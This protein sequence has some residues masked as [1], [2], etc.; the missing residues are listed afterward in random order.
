[1][2]DV[3]ISALPAA[4]TLTG[5]EQI[6]VVQGGT[7]KRT[8][9]S[10]FATG[11]VTEAPAASTDNVIQPTAD[12]VPF[13]IRAFTTQ[14]TSL[15]EWLASNGSTVLAYVNGAGQIGASFFVDLTGVGP[16]LQTT[17]A[18]FVI[19]NRTTITNIP[20]IVKGMA[21]QSGHL[22]QWQDS[23]AAV[24]ASITSAGHVT[25]N[26]GAGFVGPSLQYETFTGPWLFL[27]TL[28]VTVQNRTTVGNIPFVVK[29]MASQSGDLQQW[30]DDSGTSLSYVKSD[31]R[32]SIDF[33]GPFHA[34]VDAG[35]YVRPRALNAASIPIAVR[36]AAAQTADLQQWQNSGGSVLAFV[37]ASGG[38]FASG[39][40]YTGS[41][42]HTSFTGPSIF[43]S[44]AA[45]SVVNA[46]SIANV[47]L[48]VKGM[49]GQS[50][51]LQQWQ[52]TGGSILA[53]INA[54]GY[55]STLLGIV[56][57]S[58]QDLSATGPSISLGVNSTFILNRTAVGNIPLI[59][60]GMAGQTGDLQQWK[61]NAGSPV[62]KI[63]N[64]GYGTFAGVVVDYIFDK[65]TLN[66]P[67]ITMAAASVIVTNPSAIGNIPFV[68]RGV[69]G[70]TGSLQQWQ[71]S[72]ANILTLIDPAGKI[73]TGPDIEILTVGQGL[74]FKSPDGTRYRLTVANGGALSAVAA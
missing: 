20:L 47:P 11:Y 6:P 40:L 42:S 43:F 19:N 23:S 14:T 64:T 46:S 8:T 32:I 24:L 57:P 49:A 37:G 65:G 22:Q 69:S 34:T 66:G 68:V 4:S 44:S 13:R 5:T 21:S 48:V 62:A 73:L 56:A 12:V 33:G 60:N 38:I 31:G 25:T 72:A 28:S 17:S 52:N 45:V 26:T 29:G 63:S 74:I 61:V 1:M 15:Q 10:A 16:Y 54:S 36:G 70:Q 50:G 67:S 9:V 55:F 71:D 59:V 58:L 27:N 41:L 7:T 3:K 53:N 2:A 35:L 18:S 30:Q 51:D 39:G